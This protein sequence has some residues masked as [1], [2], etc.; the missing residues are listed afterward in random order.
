[1]VVLLYLRLPR[2]VRQ[3]GQP[4][5]R[6]GRQRDAL[7]HARRVGGVAPDDGARVEGGAAHLRRELVGR[8]L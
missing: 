5:R 7:E 8:F 2:G 4:D 6:L 3:D 1:M